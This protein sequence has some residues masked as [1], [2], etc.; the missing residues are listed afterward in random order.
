[1]KQTQMYVCTLLEF[2][3]VDVVTCCTSGISDWN[4]FTLVYVQLHE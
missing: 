2:I 4:G 3:L 1:M